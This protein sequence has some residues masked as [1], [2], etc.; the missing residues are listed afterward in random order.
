MLT[1]LLMLF[2]APANVNQTVQVDESRYRVLVRGD[3]VKVFNKAL[4]TGQRANGSTK[5]RDQMR[6]AVSL[7]TGC[8]IKDDFWRGAVLVGVIDCSEKV[9]Q[10]G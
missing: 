10:T 6:Q 8:Q 9:N 5:Q 7:V 1:A 2:A 4:I 3:E